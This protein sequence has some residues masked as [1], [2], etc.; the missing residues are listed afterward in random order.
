MGFAQPVKA[1]ADQGKLAHILGA[2][3]LVTTKP[4]YELSIRPIVQNLQIR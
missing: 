2:S 4:G 1:P 3:R